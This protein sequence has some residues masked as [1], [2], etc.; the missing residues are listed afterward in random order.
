[1]DGS[2]RLGGARN[3]KAGIKSGQGHR[4]VVAHDEAA[5]RRRHLSSARNRAQQRA[6][7]GKGQGR[8][9]LLPQ[10][11]P[12]GPLDGSCGVTVARVDDGGTR[13]TLRRAGE[14]GQGKIRGVWD[15]LGCVPSCGRRGGAYRDKGHRWGLNV[16]EG[17]SSSWL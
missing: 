14:R 17:T 10:G 5:R 9:S 7:E 3:T 12:Q 2:G 16:G 8:G 4:R 6:R 15:K 13:A 11:E 1:V